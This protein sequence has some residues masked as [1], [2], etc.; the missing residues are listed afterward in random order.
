MKKFTELKEG[1]YIYYIDHCKLHKQLV[2]YA[3][4][5]E[6][7]D[8]YKDWYGTHHITKWKEFIIKAG[9]GTEI[10]GNINWLNCSD[11]TYHGIHRFAC[12][13]A[14][15]EYIKNMI[16]WRKKRYEKFTKKAMAEKQILDRYYYEKNRIDK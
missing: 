3:Q 8:E 7:V 6:I 10:S 12:I 2:T 16:E 9:R 13:E 4:G 11:F 1:D 15:N 14:A 5:N